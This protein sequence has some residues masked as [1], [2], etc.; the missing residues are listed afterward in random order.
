MIFFPRNN[1]QNEINAPN[2]LDLVVKMI[3][4]PLVRFD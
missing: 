1:Q 4:G 2:I 3:F